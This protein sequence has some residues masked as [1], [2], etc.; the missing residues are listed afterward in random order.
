MSI[1][2]PAVALLLVIDQVH[3]LRQR[4]RSGAAGDYARGGVFNGI[5]QPF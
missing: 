2:I 1:A 4:G 5:D 3:V